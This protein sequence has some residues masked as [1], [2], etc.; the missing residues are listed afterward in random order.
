MAEKK[1]QSKKQNSN[2]QQNLTDD[3]LNLLQ[4]ET[5]L[6]S[7]Q[8]VISSA[9]HV[10]EEE[11]AAG[12]LA[13]KQIEKKVLDFDTADTNPENLMNRIRRDTHEALDLFL[14][15][16]ASLTKQVGVLTQ[17]VEKANEKSTKDKTAPTSSTNT[18]Y[19][20][21]EAPIPAGDKAIIEVQ[22]QDDKNQL[23]HLCCTDFT[24]GNGDRIPIK[25]ITLSPSEI[26]LVAN[27]EQVIRITI[28]TNKKSSVGNYN[29][30][31]T[32]LERPELKILLSFEIR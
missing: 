26:N 4:P 32:L 16:F 6:N 28:Q 8:K 11:I 1:G 9:V 31:L 18:F 13:A 7:A 21:S 30:L 15:A 10:L 2:T 24:G 19:F 27:E 3:L 23:V 12:I 14:D 29:G 25:Q 5:M 20:E 22:L 17:T